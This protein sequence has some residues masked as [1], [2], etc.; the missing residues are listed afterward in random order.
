MKKALIII[1]VVLAIAAAG[2][3][4]PGV[5]R[6]TL[7]YESRVTVNKPRAEV[8]K[9]FFDEANM[10][11]WI[12]GFKSIELVSGKK[13]EVGSKYLLIVE[14]ESERYRLRETVTE[15][16]P[17]EVYA[18]VL[19]ADPLFDDVRVTFADD[20]G[21][22]E[23]VQREK[24]RGKNLLWRSLFFWMQSTFTDNA[25]KTLERLKRFA[26]AQ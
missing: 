3:L 5:L 14:D 13:G 1:V 11:K 24:V 19:E 25:Q 26:E 16:K 23:V 10:G 8:W 2:F 6:P 4:A 9:L 15:I 18:F 7:E 12:K 22:T 17:P 21:N 20:G